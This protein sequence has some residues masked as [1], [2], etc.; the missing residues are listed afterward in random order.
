[1]T[2]EA[3]ISTQK[4]EAARQQLSKANSATKDLNNS[5]E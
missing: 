3:Q 5:K 2:Q 4:H 1:M